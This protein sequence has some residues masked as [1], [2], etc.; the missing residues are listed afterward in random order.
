MLLPVPVFESP[1]PVVSLCLCVYEC[2]VYTHRHTVC[3]AIAC[4]FSFTAHLYIVK[5]KEMTDAVWAPVGQ[6]PKSIAAATD[7]IFE[8]SNSV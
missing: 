8:M 1:S 7:I 5:G 2:I 3:I 6:S 4:C